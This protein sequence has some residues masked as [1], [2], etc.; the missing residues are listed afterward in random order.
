M[1]ILIEQ[2]ILNFLPDKNF[3]EYC[4]Q[5]NVNIVQYLKKK[6][7]IGIGIGIGF[8]M[9]RPDLLNKIKS[10]NKDEVLNLVR[11]K[12]PDVYAVLNTPR[13][14]VWWAHQ[15]IKKMFEV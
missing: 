1:D 4:I 13:G 9:K 5:S 12:K 8:L 11:L 14:K 15:N 10:I 3:F 6:Y 7:S 2:L